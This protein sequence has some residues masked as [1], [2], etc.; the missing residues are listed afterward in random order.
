MKLAIMQP[1]LFPYL[2]YYQLMSS[3]DKF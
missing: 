2:G 1:Y 3:V